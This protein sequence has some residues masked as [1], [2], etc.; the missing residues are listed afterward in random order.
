MA[1]LVRGG[2]VLCSLDVAETVGER[3]RGLLGRDGLDGAILLTH[4]R[5]VH[6]LGMRFPIDV[7]FLNRTGKVVAVVA[8]MRPWRLG[9]SRLRARQVLEAEAGTFERW[10]L[11]VGDVLE[12][13]VA[14]APAAPD[15]T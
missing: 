12:V 13:E 1:W 10:K 4:C 2:D 9:R 15:G 7:A 6:T 5:S 11:A 3:M 14:D 8:P